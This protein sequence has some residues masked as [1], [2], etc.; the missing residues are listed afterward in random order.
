VTSIAA[1]NNDGC[2][3]AGGDFVN[4]IHVDATGRWLPLRNVLIVAAISAAF[5]RIGPFDTFSDLPGVT[6]YAYW[7]GL[8]LLLWLQVAATLHLLREP[9]SGWPW[10]MR[11]ALAALIGSVPS[12]F[13]VAWAESLLRVSRDLSLLDVAKLYGDVAL[14][15]VV[16]VLPLE[17]V[18]GNLLFRPRAAP[19]IHEPSTPTLEDLIS[20]LP[21][22]RRGA[23]IALE[24]ED[25]YL[26][27]HTDRGN[28]LIHLR[29]GDALAR[30]VGM[31]GLQVHRSWWIMRGAVT[32]LE[33]NGDRLSIVLRNGLHVPVSRTYALAVREANLPA[34]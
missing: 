20:R 24:A 5:G 28:A 21:P 26:R 4:A 18:D 3:N 9:L 12:A 19:T 23:L 8:T 13:E 7:V 11:T 15:A 34:A 31:D 1:K 33:R 16:M 17:L 25:H 6:R 22:E 27:V 30:L 14:I 10:T 2:V 29:F 32:K